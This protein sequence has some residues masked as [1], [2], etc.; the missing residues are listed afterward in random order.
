[1]KD[2]W[3]EQDY[4]QAEIA[5][6]DNKE[7]KEFM[8]INIR[9]TPDRNVFT[10]KLANEIIDM[11]NEKYREIH[12]RDVDFQTVKINLTNYM[13]NMNEFMDDGVSHPKSFNHRKIGTYDK[14]KNILR[15]WIDGVPVYENNDGKICRDSVAL[16]DCLM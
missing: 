2:N 4:Y 16:A 7:C 8:V 15:I 12:G 9:K 1:M 11:A 14:R 6:W 3:V 10:V 13:I 5:E